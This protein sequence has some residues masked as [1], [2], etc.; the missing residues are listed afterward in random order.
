MRHPSRSGT[1]G[2]IR[3]Y[4]IHAGFRVVHPLPLNVGTTPGRAA[5]T[6]V[7]PMRIR[8][9]ILL[10][11]LLCAFLPGCDNPAE[12]KEV[13]GSE[14]TFIRAAADAPPLATT[15]V[16]VWA[17]AGEGR[18]AVISYQKV[19]E[20]GGDDCLE[21]KIP[22]D[23]LWKRPDGTLFQK[24]DS[25]L[26]T[27]TVVD[28]QLFNFRFEPSGLQFRS[29]KPAE[30][31]VSYKWADRDFNGD[32]KEDNSDERFNFG[33][34]KQETDASDWTRIGTVKDADLEELRAD[35]HGFTRYAIAG[36]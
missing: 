23:A 10:A 11:A 27:I 31:R 29:D 32:G 9:S 2:A 34:W 26:I 5:P 1:G 35:I 18:R 33:I 19:G 30:L 25:I 7:P 13:P 24:G 15:Q 3:K 21:F 20:Y 6:F 14:L 28:P 4:S 16:Q 22:G 8:H 17:K 36:A 12:P